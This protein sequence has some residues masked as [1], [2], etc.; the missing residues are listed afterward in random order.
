MELIPMIYEEV[1]DRSSTVHS[2]HLEH[3]GKVYE[4]ARRWGIEPHEVLDFSANINPFGPPEGVLTAIQHALT[5]TGLRVYPDSHD[6]LDAIASKH[7]VMPDEVIVGSGAASLIF[8]VM[9]ALSPRKVL[10]LCPA[11]VEYSRASAG[12]N[13]QVITELLTEENGFA[14]DFARLV[15]TIK[16]GQVDL[17]ILNSPHNPTGVLYPRDAL[18]SLVEAAEKH[19]VA[20]L[21]DEAFVD[22][23]PQASLISLATTR[24]NLIVLRSLTKFYAM[25]GIRVGYAVC[26]IKLAG[27]IREQIDPWSVSTVA[28][29]AG[30]AALREDEFGAESWRVNDLAREEFANGL[31]DLGLTVFPSAANFLLAKLPHGS[32]ADLQNWLEPEHILIRRCDSF[33]GLG[34]DYVRLAVLSRA[35]NARLLGAVGRCSSPTVKEGSKIR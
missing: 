28:L 34:D 3:G 21:L 22:Y 11:F 24:P 2:I 33:H 7:Q 25:P 31:R 19:D 29:E 15:R 20:V 23:A 27:R 6:F 10:M 1:K 16:E 9:H 17:V 26:S 32:G 8:A 30:C 13:A 12:V 35:D 4:A 5:P 14:P 18:I